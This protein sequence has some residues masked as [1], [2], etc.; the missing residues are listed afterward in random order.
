ML[1]NAMFF[2]G[3]IV[4]R[5]IKNDGNLALIAFFSQKIKIINLRHIY[6]FYY[7]VYFIDN[8]HSYES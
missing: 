3:I 4:D 6:E 8:G 2:A 5:L 7:S 1:K